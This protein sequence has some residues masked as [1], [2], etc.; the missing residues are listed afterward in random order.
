MKPLLEAQR[1]VLAAVGV[2]SPEPVALDDALGRSLAADV[3]AVE[4][5][6][7]FANSAMDG[8][9]VRAVDVAHAPVEL[10]VV[11][12]VPAGHVASRAVESGTAIRIM[13][14]APLPVGADTVVRVEDT[15][16]AGDRVRILLAVPAGT[17]VRAAGSDVGAGSTVFTSGTTLAPAHIGVLAALGTTAALVRRRPRV[18]IVSTGDEVVPPETAVLDPGRIRD[19]NRPLLRALLAEVGAEI[20]DLG[21]VGDDPE[22][23]AATIAEGATNADAVVTSGGVSV[24]DHDLVKDVLSRLGEIELWR[25]AMQPA[26]PFAFGTIGGT[27]LFGLPG[28]PVSALVAFEQ[29]AG[30]AF[31]VMAGSRGAF[32]PRLWGI[33]G[34]AV[35]TDPE[36]V[37]FLRVRLSW[38][39]GTPVARLAGSQGSNVLSAAADADAFAVVPVGEAV[40]AA[41]SAVILEMHRWAPNRTVEE[42]LGE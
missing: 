20:L 37:V 13:T 25:V 18:A 38:E 4:N 6:P 16:P 22:R 3:L 15:A 19:A 1:E 39:N 34:E 14:G 5:V 10:T 24:G 35:S 32:R 29:F 33:L 2:L 8:F 27:P 23:L 30:P 7:P 36:K 21:I 12:D 26:K 28:N 9:A 41:G 11:E 40:L 17:A 42:A 31:R